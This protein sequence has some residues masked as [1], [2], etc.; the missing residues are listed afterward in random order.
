MDKRVAQGPQLFV[1]PTEDIRMGED[2]LEQAVMDVERSRLP[3]ECVKRSRELE[4][5]THT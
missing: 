4:L 5:H 1:E 2:A 3:P